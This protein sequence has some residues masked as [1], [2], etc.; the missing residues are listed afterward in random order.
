MRFAH[1]DQSK[2]IATAYTFYVPHLT[3]KK[4][5]VQLLKIFKNEIFESDKLQSPR[6]WSTHISNMLRFKT[7]RK[8]YAVRIFQE[9]GIT[10]KIGSF[11]KNRRVN[12]MF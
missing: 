9:T 12:S 1:D 8:Q 5:K 2:Y 7:E 6:E 3:L 4:F 10:I 11:W